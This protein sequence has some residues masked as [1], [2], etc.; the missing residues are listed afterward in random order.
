MTPT[1]AAPILAALQVIPQSQNLMTPCLKVMTLPDGMAY[2]WDV[3][4][5]I[6]T[7]IALIKSM[8]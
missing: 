4:A 6:K 1:Q 7:A 2:H 8:L 5:A 3:S